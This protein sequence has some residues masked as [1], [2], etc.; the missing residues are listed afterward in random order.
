MLERIAKVENEKVQ[1]RF[2]SEGCFVRFR[3]GKVVVQSETVAY[4]TR[5]IIHRE[6]EIPTHFPAGVEICD[7][8]FALS[9]AAGSGAR[10]TIREVSDIVASAVSTAR[11]KVKKEAE[12]TGIPGWLWEKAT[13]SNGHWRKN[14]FQESDV[15]NL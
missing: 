3:P 15:T 1:L 10:H 7:S 9:I 6:I 13:F 12:K 4:W 8:S 5:G 11:A 14:N 2:L